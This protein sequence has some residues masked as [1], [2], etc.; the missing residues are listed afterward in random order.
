MVEF[1]LIVLILYTILMITAFQ[2]YFSQNRICFLFFC[3][4][5]VTEEIGPYLVNGW[6]RACSSDVLLESYEITVL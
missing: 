1:G 4:H 5:D 6:I 2:R 3:I